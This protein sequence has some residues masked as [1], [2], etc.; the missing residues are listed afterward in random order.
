[1]KK[2]SG[3]IGRPCVVRADRAGVF[4][5]TL[6]IR[7]GN[8]VVLT[9]CRRVFYWDGAASISQIA[10]SGVSKP[11][12]CKITESVAEILVMGVIEIIPMTNIAVKNINEVIAWKS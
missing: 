10:K 8:E 3:F 1:M 4:I 5:G 7:K 11:Q 6:K 9:D 12:N 2:K